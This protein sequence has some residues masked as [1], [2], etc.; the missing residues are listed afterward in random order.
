MSVRFAVISEISTKSVK[1]NIHSLKR[2]I[3]SY[4]R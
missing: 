4:N 2:V 3:N 1:E